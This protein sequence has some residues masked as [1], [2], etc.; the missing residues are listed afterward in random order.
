MYVANRREEDRQ[1][2]REKKRCATLP[3]LQPPLPAV[4]LDLVVLE[5]LEGLALA[6][7]DLVL[8]VDQVGDDGGGGGA[9]VLAHLG[10]VAR[11]L[12]RLVERRLDAG[13]RR[14]VVVVAVLRV[15]AAAVV[16]EPVVNLL[17]ERVSCLFD[18][19]GG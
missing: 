18:V 1:E 12:D 7:A 4:L 19:M 3:L 17:C 15:A 16:G 6:V 8:A 5:G 14:L 2:A 11:L 10:R 13:E 9:G